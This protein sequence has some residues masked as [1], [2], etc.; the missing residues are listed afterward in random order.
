MLI[1][2]PKSSLGKL[3]KIVEKGIPI[4]SFKIGDQNLRSFL[5]Y[6]LLINVL[7]IVLNKRDKLNNSSVNVSDPF[8]ISTN[9]LLRR[10]GK[11]INKPAII[12]YLPN[13]LFQA[14]MRVNR[15]QWILVRL[16]GN[17]Y[18]SNDKLQKEFQR[19]KNFEE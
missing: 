5:S 6:D 18:I 15:L 10:F 11:S 16:F 13:F 8:P 19:S 7:Q 9:N 1:N 12:F 17:F 2:H 14:M 3:F 4:P